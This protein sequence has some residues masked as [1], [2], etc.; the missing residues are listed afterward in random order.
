M[1][2]PTLAQGNEIMNLILRNKVSRDTIQFL[3]T[4]G[5]MANLFKLRLENFLQDGKKPHDSKY[6]IVQARFLM[7]LGLLPEFEVVNQYYLD[8]VDPYPVPSR[9][10]IQMFEE[11]GV[12]TVIDETKKHLKIRTQ[13][14]QVKPRSAEFSLIRFPVLSREERP[15]FA[16]NPAVILNAAGYLNADVYDLVAFSAVSNLH[17]VT[18][19]PV[20]A[21][22]SV[23][24][25]STSSTGGGFIY[26]SHPTLHCDDIQKGEVWFNKTGLKDMDFWT[27]DYLCLVRNRDKLARSPKI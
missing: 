1:E 26:N 20:V 19:T 15:N 7:S 22:K 27:S 17:I 21:L 18:T 6:H 10:L 25:T 9:S 12:K 14:H 13:G 2:S 11:R 23:V 24:Q 3:L 4:S 5:M 16:Y 8:T